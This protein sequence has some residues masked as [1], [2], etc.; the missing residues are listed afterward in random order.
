MG[1]LFGFPFLGLLAVIQTSVL[2]HL[3]LLDGSPDLILL[4]VLGWAL[5]GMA[6]QALVWGLAGG[7]LLDFYSGLPVGST[8]ITLLLI[9][10]LVSL[11]EGRFWEAHFLM[12]MSVMLVASFLY[13][14]GQLAAL[15]L[16]G[17]SIPLDLAL[18]RVIL[19]SAFLNILLVL[20]VVQLARSL[21]EVLYPPEVGI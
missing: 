12:P 18:G 3:R 21:R 5:V 6:N 7:L 17:R 2:T 8:S 1:Y 14:I 11:A 4:A 10:F 19:P 13:H 9:V 16:I 20:P 15:L